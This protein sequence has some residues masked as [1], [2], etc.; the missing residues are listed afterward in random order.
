MQTD[1][2]E[3]SQEQIL[4]IKNAIDAKKTI[5]LSANWGVGKT[6]F[7]NSI[8]TTHY[9]NKK[10]RYVSLF[11]IETMDRLIQRLI[12]P[13][14][15]LKDQSVDILGNKLP[16]NELIGF[17]QGGA[18][19]LISQIKDEIIVIDDLER[20]HLDYTLILG[21][22]DK[23]KEHNSIIF[24]CNRNKINSS[25]FLNQ[26]EKVSDRIIDDVV[27]DFNIVMKKIIPNQILND[28]LYA[29]FIMKEEN[30]RIAIKLGQYFKIIE[31]Q[32]PYLSYK[33][34]RLFSCLAIEKIK[35]GYLNEFYD[36]IANDSFQKIESYLYNREVNVNNKL[37]SSIKIKQNGIELS[38]E[39][40][41][42]E[43]E[44]FVEFIRKIQDED[45]YHIK[46][47]LLSLLKND[48]L[49][50][51]DFIRETL[52][53]HP[54]LKKNQWPIDILYPIDLI[55]QGSESEI[56]SLN[57]NV[58]EGIASFEKYLTKD[59]L[60]DFNVLYLILSSHFYISEELGLP[61]P[62]SI[63]FNLL[64]ELVQG[65]TSDD[66]SKI[67]VPTSVVGSFILNNSEISKLIYDER[68]QRS[69]LRMLSVILENDIVEFYKHKYE[70]IILD[71]I[72]EDLLDII[73]RNYIN[74]SK[75]SKEIISIITRASYQGDKKE[76][77]DQAT[78]YLKKFY[79]NK[80]TSESDMFVK[81]RINKLLNSNK[82]KENIIV[83]KDQLSQKSQINYHKIRITTQEYKDALVSIKNEEKNSEKYIELKALIFQ[84]KQQVMIDKYSSED[85]I[86][87]DDVPKIEK[88][89]KS[90]DKVV[91]VSK[92]DRYLTTAVVGCIYTLREE[93][94]YKNKALEGLIL[95]TTLELGESLIGEK[96]IEKVE[97]K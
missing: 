78:L 16:L 65:I 11:G 26:I 18:N 3:Y 40:L 50:E 20:S 10:N 14:I 61:T 8:L 49:E 35:N 48:F 67:R 32:I 95:W 56:K 55:E 42:P 85:D 77:S 7:I 34:I 57:D 87:I 38:S 88:G 25:D 13:T 21:L 68:S 62:K 60:V 19:L 82:F 73:S 5:L 83:E 66:L 2:S 41:K 86:V 54:L 59:S 46:A 58:S 93:S 45:F 89:F 6:Y 22:I 72:N 9:K 80:L 75:L 69:Y 92:N 39:L 94:K 1:F 29:F 52:S 37:E 33:E 96:D 90:G 71:L 76:K 36:L 47:S 63:P 44:L 51:K 28:V 31:N 23:L 64:E 79:Q 12:N 4:S 70:D 81:K 97:K 84:Y 91:F 74:G 43:Y 17:M 53:Y 30:L 24:I 27:I 15:D